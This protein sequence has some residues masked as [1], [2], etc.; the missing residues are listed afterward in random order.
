MTTSATPH[1][2]WITSRAAGIAALVLA[3]LAVSLGLLMSTKLLRKRGPDLLA[4]HEALSLA[5][6]V[7]IVVHGVALLGDQYLHPSIADIAIPFVSG[8]KTFWTSTGIIAGWGLALLGLSYYARRRIGAARW[9]KLHRFTALLWVAGLAH[10]LGE[11]TDAGQIWFLAMI[12]IVAVPAV[13]LLLT[14]YLTVPAPPA[15][16]RSAGGPRPGAGSRLPAQP[17][18]PAGAPATARGTGAGVHRQTRERP[19]TGIAQL[20]PAT[21]PAGTR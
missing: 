4:T 20:S 17:H 2:F 12:A 13:L 10:A 7:A 21:E 14:R 15:G 5:T 6:I 3:S 8:Y 1:L 18:P 16:S 19:R 9:R 11:G